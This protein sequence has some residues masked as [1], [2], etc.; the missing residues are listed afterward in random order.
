ENA[1]GNTDGYLPGFDEYLKPQREDLH[2]KWDA[3][4]SREKRSRTLF[5]Q[6]TIKVDEVAQ[7][8]SAARAAVGSAGDVASFVRDAVVA[9]HGAAAPPAP[10][11]HPHAP[12][13]DREDAPR[14]RMRG[15]RF[16]RS[17]RVGDVALAFR[18]RGSA[19]C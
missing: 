2:R 4:S 18:G 15:S 8:L 3:A 7:E 19:R 1:G 5:A 17:P 11:P 12:R 16:H 9:S 10:P 6:E 13:R 14:R